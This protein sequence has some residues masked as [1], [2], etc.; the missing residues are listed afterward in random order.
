MVSHLLVAPGLVDFD[1]LVDFHL[2]VPTVPP[3]CPAAQL[4]LLN[5]HQPRQNTAGMAVSKCVKLQRS[6]R[7]VSAYACL[8]TTQI[9]GYNPDF[10]VVPAVLSAVDMPA[11][12]DRQWNTQNSTQ[13]SPVHEQMGHP[14]QIFSIIMH[15]I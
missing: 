7:E 6:A 4:L 9:F 10:W 1:C 15:A 3:S 13:P 8:G 2:G 5:C 11:V 14:V 12:L